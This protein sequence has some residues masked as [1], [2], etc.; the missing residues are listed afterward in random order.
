VGQTS[1]SPFLAPSRNAVQDAA[2][3]VITVSGVSESRIATRPSGRT[4]R[5]R[6]LLPPLPLLRDAFFQI[7]PSIEGQNALT[8]RYTEEAVRFLKGHKD[9]PFFLYLPMMLTHGLND[10][11]PD[12]PDYIASIS[13]KNWLA[14]TQ[15]PSRIG[16]RSIAP[17]TGKSWNS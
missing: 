3:Q 8:A 15:W 16:A 13:G 2:E 12:S 1:S 17:W 4:V 14:G 6:Q 9:G 5:S 10:A 7:G 11:T